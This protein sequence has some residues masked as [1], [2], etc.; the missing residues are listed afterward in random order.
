MQIKQAPSA[1]GVPFSAVTIVWDEPGPVSGAAWP[2][3]L[4][5]QSSEIVRMKMVRMA[6]RMPIKDQATAV[7]QAGRR[8]LEVDLSLRS[9][10]CPLQLVVSAPE[11]ETHR[12]HRYLPISPGIVSKY[13]AV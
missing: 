10:C 13:L 7:N 8:S 4:S 6:V 2:A 3:H 1:P 9:T 5:S 11:L 12:G